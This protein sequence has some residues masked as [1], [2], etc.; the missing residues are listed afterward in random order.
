MK[1]L[2]VLHKLGPQYAKAKAQRVQI[3]ESLRSVKALEMSKSS[4][5][6][7]GAQERDAYASEAYRTAVTGLSVAVEN[8]ETLRWK[9]LTAQAALDVYRTMEASNRALDRRAA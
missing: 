2:E 8:E 1:S 5:T 7:I 9:L 6:A 4:E 3:E